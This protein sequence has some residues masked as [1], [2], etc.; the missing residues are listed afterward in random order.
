[1]ERKRERESQ[2]ER[3]KKRE[4]GGWAVGWGEFGLNTV[5]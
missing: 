2:R 5:K 1:M 4:R 3:K